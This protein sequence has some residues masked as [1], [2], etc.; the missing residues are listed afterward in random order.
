MT[1][2]RHEKVLALG[3]CRH[4]RRVLSHSVAFVEIADL[5]GRIEAAAKAEAA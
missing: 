1:L 4:Q 3:R 2:L 5:V